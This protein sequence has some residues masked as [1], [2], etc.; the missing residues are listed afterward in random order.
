MLSE[1]EG[2]TAI[3]VGVLRGLGVEVGAT[4]LWTVGRTGVIGFRMPDEGRAVGVP[5]RA[6]DAIVVATI[7]VSVDIVRAASAVV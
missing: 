5:M 2:P 4:V 7:G 1:G 3:G 6:E